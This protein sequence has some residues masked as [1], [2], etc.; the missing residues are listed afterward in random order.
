MSRLIDLSPEGEGVK[1]CGIPLPST[2]LCNALLIAVIQLFISS[3]D[4]AWYTRL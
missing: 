4:V 3:S 2:A 1:A